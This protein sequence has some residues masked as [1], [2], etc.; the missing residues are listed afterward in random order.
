MAGLLIFF[1]STPDLTVTRFVLALM[2][3]VY[4]SIGIKIE[5]QTLLQQLGETCADYRRRVGMFF[6]FASRDA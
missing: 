2:L 3:T 1:W 4:I 5:E 6:T